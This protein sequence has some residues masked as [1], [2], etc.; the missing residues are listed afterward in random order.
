VASLDSVLDRENPLF[1]KLDAF[2]RQ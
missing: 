2:L 1:A